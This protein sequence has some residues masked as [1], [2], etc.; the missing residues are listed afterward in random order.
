MQKPTYRV[1]P[2]KGGRTFDVEMTAP[3]CPPTIVNCFNTE[4]NAW[5]WVYEQRQVERVAR[6]LKRDPEGMGAHN[7]SPWLAASGSLR[8]SRIS[9]RVA[10]LSAFASA[11]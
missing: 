6:R 4:A 7:R 2:R 3:N 11:V 9:T 10:F 1:I 8:N 5:Q